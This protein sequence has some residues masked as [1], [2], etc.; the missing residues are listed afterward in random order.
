MKPVIAI[1]D[2]GRDEAEFQRYVQW[3][4]RW[5][6]G[7]GILRMTAGETA[8]SD[9]ASCSGLILS[10]GGDVHPRLYGRSDALELVAG[11]DERRD[12]MEFRLIEKA[13]AERLPVL[14]ICRGTQVFTVA[15]GGTLI[16]D[17]ERTGRPSHRKDG[18]VDR[19]HDVVVERESALH[20]V[21]G[22]DSGE[23]NSSHHQSVDRTGEHLVVVARAADG[24]VESVEW[25]DRTDRPFLM[26]VQWHPERMSPESPFSRQPGLAFAREAIRRSGG[27]HEV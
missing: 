9:L 1:T 7:A 17:I 26:L 21:L 4:R 15:M 24:I 5:V 3:I 14:G 13:L 22:V 2:R 19:V 25:K 27:T 12:E 18:G 20:R 23:I 10:G 6:E 8:E 11:V 16:P